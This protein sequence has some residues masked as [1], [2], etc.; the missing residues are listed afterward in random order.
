MS[1]KL[2]IR[3]LV[4]PLVWEDRSGFQ[5]AQTPWGRY[6]MGQRGEI[7]IWAWNGQDERADS[8]AA[9]Q[10]AAEADYRARIGAALDLDKIA[11]LVEALRLAD[12]ALSGANMNMS[13]VKRKVHAALAALGDMEV[14]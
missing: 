14:G 12:A 2:M 9:A 10:A 13:A 4:K 8:E 3:A 11:A 6:A 5:T 7:W 1:D